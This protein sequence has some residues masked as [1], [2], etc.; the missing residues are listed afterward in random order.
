MTTLALFSN[1]SFFNMSSSRLHTLV[2]PPS[3]VLFD[4]EIPVACPIVARITLIIPG[5]EEERIESVFYN[6]NLKGHPKHLV[7]CTIQSRANERMVRSMV[8]DLWFAAGVTLII[9]KTRDIVCNPPIVYM[10][11]FRAGLRFPLLSLLLDLLNHYEIT[12]S[13]LVPNAIDS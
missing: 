3:L 7:A 11:H 8:V 1:K 12:L 5:D 4:V 10:D 2:T 6:S 9:P 13:Q